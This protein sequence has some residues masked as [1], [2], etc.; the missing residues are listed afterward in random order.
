MARSGFPS[1]SRSAITTCIG[2]SPPAISALG[3]SALESSTPLEGKVTTNPTLA[4]AVSP[5]TVTQ[6]GLYVAP[7]GT[8]TVKA[9]VEAAVT[10]A[11][12]APKYTMFCE[13]TAL[14]LLPPMVTE[15][16]IGPE[17]GEKDEI[18]G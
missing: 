17:D 8:L 18:T 9:S 10:F 1:P 16:P 11:R 6:G 13:A 12:T 15:A 2:P 5:P 14:K 7:K 4:Q 3:P